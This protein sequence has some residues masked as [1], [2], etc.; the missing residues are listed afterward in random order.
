M[1]LKKLASTS[2]SFI[3]SLVLK[4]KPSLTWF[5]HFVAARRSLF[6][7]ALRFGLVELRMVDRYDPEAAPLGA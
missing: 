5:G 2:I 3:Y 6:S 7:F 4:C 1:V